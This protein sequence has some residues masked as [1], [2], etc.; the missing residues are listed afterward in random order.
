MHHE[1]PAILLAI[2][3]AIVVVLIAYWAIMP[4]LYGAHWRARDT[5][6]F[7]EMVRNRAVSEALAALWIIIA[8]G[9]VIFLTIISR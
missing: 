2:P 4:R 7:K 3:A 6:D 9:T 5:R 8:M 1:S